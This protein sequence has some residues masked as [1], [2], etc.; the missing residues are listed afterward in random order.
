MNNLNTFSVFSQF[1]TA[2]MGTFVAGTL[3]TGGLTLIITSLAKAGMRAHADANFRGR[4]LHMREAGKWIKAMIIDLSASIVYG[5]LSA[6]AIKILRLNL[7]L[8]LAVISACTIFMLSRS[9]N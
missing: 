4:E 8:E 2:A 9:I 1:A 6:T 7:P 3:V 5:I